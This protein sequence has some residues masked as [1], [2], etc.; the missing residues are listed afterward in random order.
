MALQHWTDGLS[1]VF[2]TITHDGVLK[3]SKQLDIMQGDLLTMLGCLK[4]ILEFAISMTPTSKN[5]SDELDADA[6]DVIDLDD[7]PSLQHNDEEWS[8]LY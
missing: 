5:T 6:D 3:Q 8:L 2:L 7:S 4:Y 1:Y